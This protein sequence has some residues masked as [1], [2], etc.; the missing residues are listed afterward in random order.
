MSYPWIFD[1]FARGSEENFE[2]G[3]S[4][5]EKNDF[6]VLIHEEPKQA[7]DGNGRRTVIENA[8]YGEPQWFYGRECALSLPRVRSLLREHK[9]FQKTR[10]CFEGTGCNWGGFLRSR[11]NCER[12]SE[13][14]EQIISWRPKKRLREEITKQEEE[15]IWVEQEI[16][17]TVAELLRTVA[18]KTRNQRLDRTKERKQLAS[19][20]YAT[21]NENRQ[22]DQNALKRPCRQESRYRNKILLLKRSL[23][24]LRALEFRALQTQLEWGP[25]C[26]RLRSPEMFI[27]RLH[28]FR[29]ILQS[30]Y[31][32]SSSVEQ[33]LHLQQP[34]S[35][36]PIVSSLMNH[37][38]FTIS[39]S[40]HVFV[41]RLCAITNATVTLQWRS[42]SVYAHWK[43]PTIFTV[44]CR[45]D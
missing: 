43:K 13:R 14:H 7:Y 27:C 24:Y 2:H 32:L 18:F 34:T 28:L 22:V 9:G 3:T 37:T 33:Q 15:L 45:P 16:E 31:R 44:H 17:R 5:E 30:Q 38:C 10:C 8:S 42:R 4:E 12:I 6:E 19:V 11:R 39:N 23:L 41:E 1:P 35:A 21:E 29:F 25:D 40:E 36:T 20:N 26:L